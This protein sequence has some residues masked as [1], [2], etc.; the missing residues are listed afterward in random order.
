MADVSGKVKDPVLVLARWLRNRN[1][2]E[3]TML[4]MLGG[5]LLLLLLWRTIEDHDTL[6]VLA[7]LSH[8]AGIAVLAF[9]IHSRKSVAGDQGHGMEMYTPCLQINKASY[10]VCEH[11]LLVCY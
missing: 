8:F 2:R 3:R 6:F 5:V 11:I 10:S 9:K 1:A 4:G 7:E